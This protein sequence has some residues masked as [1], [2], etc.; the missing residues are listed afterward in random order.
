MMICLLQED[1]ELVLQSSTEIEKEF[2]TS[3]E[4]KTLG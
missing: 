4:G 1:R 3:D 2:G